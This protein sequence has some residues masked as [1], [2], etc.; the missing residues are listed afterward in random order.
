LKTWLTHFEL[1]I[2]GGIF[3][4]VTGKTGLSFFQWGRCSPTHNSE[5]QSCCGRSLFPRPFLCPPG[6]DAM[7]V[8]A[9]TCDRVLTCCVLCLHCRCMHISG[10]FRC[11]STHTQLCICVCMYMH[12]SHDCVFMHAQLCMSVHLCA[13]M[14]THACASLYI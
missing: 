7:Y 3:P 8:H 1:C 4:F 9:C 5:V 14:F 2:L 11:V 6:E 13:N 12:I 10:V